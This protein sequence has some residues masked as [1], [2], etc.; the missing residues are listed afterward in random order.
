MSA[1]V[2]LSLGALFATTRVRL[3]ERFYVLA[4]AAVLALL[5]GVSRAALG[6]HWATD[7]LGGWAVGLAWAMVWLLI[8]LRLGASSFAGNSV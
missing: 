2:F 6:V 4:V 3:A 8:A 5:V 7:V 1:I